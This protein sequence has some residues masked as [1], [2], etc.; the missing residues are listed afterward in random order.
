MPLKAIGWSV[1]TGFSEVVQDPS[2]TQ[3][4]TA[5]IAIFFSVMSA[6]G[7]TWMPSRGVDGAGPELQVEPVD[8]ADSEVGE[9]KVGQAPRPPV[10]GVAR[11]AVERQS[12]RPPM[13]ASPQAVG[14]ANGERVVPV[15]EMT[16]FI[17]ELE[18]ASHIDAATR[19]QI[20]ATAFQTPPEL[21]TQMI[22]Q[23]RAL[24]A[25]GRSAGAV[26]SDTTALTTSQPAMVPLP[27]E[28]NAS[29]TRETVVAAS[30]TEPIQAQESAPLPEEEETSSV[31]RQLAALLRE[32]K[33]AQGGASDHGTTVSE[34]EK[35]S[36]SAVESDDDRA[37]SN[38]TW[39]QLVDSAIKK[40]EERRKRRL[41]SDLDEEDEA[42]LRMLY[43]I[44]NRRDDAVRVIASLEPEMQEFWSKQFFGLATLLNSDL[45]SD[46]SNRLIE[47]KRNLDEA[48]RRLGE[49]APL[50]VRNLAFITNVDS[51][52]VYTPFDDYEFSTGDPV[53]LYAEVENYRCKETARG[54]HTALRSTYEIFDSSRQKVAEHEFSTNEEYC[55]NP[56]RDFFTVCEFKIPENLEPGKFV[57]RL[58][59]ADLNGD[60]AGESSIT[61]HI[62]EKN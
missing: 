49:S 19:S 22:R 15:A 40:L 44:A 55:K 4:R 8:L 21:Q 20:M 48:L 54:Y 59:V 1:V 37:G 60:K 42:R 10:E 25:L 32:M 11:P 18:A 2:M 52:G 41:D 23:Y 51:Y 28:S 31:E 33:N 50:F 35:S 27:A 53:L 6:P 26:P 61:F 39:E 57:L 58:T 34:D 36:T 47:S 29:G 46:R 12:E 62:R 17:K 5:L 9:P 38:A 45:I 14:P 3:F 30:H 24:L 16:A 7:C 56:R 43:L 13:S